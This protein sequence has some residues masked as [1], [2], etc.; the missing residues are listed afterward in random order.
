MKSI[1][2][3]IVAMLLFMTCIAQSKKPSK[4]SNVQYSPALLDVKESVYIP[5][6]S[7]G[8][9]K[10]FFENRTESVGNSYKSILS[11]DN[12]G[13][14]TI[15]GDSI[16]EVGMYRIENKVYITIRKI[17][18]DTYKTILSISLFDNSIKPIDIT[19]I[20]FDCYEIKNK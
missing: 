7:Y 3:T 16:K 12:N 1:I 19:P 4:D 13:V 2:A 11:I 6:N 10:Q 15:Q 5:S 20:C 9:E 14:I 18:K 17:G 8:R